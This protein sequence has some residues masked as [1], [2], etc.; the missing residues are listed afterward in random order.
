MKQVYLH[1]RLAIL[2][3]LVFSACAQDEELAQIGENVAA[4][5]VLAIRKVD[6]ANFTT[7]TATR[8]IND[9]VTVSFEAGN[10]LEDVKG[11]E[12]GI[13][14]IGDDEKGFANVSFKYIN[15]NG[16]N[17]WVNK[18][19]VSYTSKIKKA[20]AYF[21]YARMMKDG[22]EFIPSSVDELKE[23]KKKEE[24]AEFKDKDLLIA[25]ISDIQSPQLT[26]GF[27]H[28]FSLL[29]FSAEATIKIAGEE[30]SYFLDIANI[31]F[32]I[33]DRQYT[34]DLVDSKY[35]CLIDEAELPQNNFRYFYT[36]DNTA[37]VKT[38]KKTMA[39]ALN[40]CYVLP[41][42]TS[43]EGTEGFAVGDFFCVSN[44]TDNIVIIP[45]NAAAIPE[46]LTCKGVVFHVM[47]GAAFDSYK[48]INGLT[49]ELPGYEGSHGLVV[50]IK[51]GQPFGA[52]ND[53][54]KIQAALGA[55]A[56]Y[57]SLD[58]SNGYKLTQALK[59]AEG[60]NFTALDNHADDVLKNATSWYAPSFN[61][62]KYLIRGKQYN[63]VSTAGQVYINGQLGK[64][65]GVQLGGTLPSVTYRERGG[66]KG[67]Q[68]MQ[69]GVD[70]WIGMP[71]ESFIPI[72]G[73]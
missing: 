7:G 64:I 1:L 39:L 61:E 29:T 58:V 27:K 54:A 34:P 12:I 60:V 26:I 44:S 50:S 73:F 19:G 21:P 51:N 45:G 62:L 33:G 20:I 38:L 14:L 32:S 69:N 25:E 5:D 18:D 24:A 70:G 36:I 3:L 52:N 53:I 15:E 31:A 43:S 17:K 71:G 46:S 22:E 65:N 35:V 9:A 13:L 56:D 6:V 47:D 37:Y 55:V 68:T 59:G 48:E 42:P 10:S 2:S 8:V 23:F 4:S 11:D 49:D 57:N 16:A 41:C 28:A 72:C 40:Q 66:D 63:E 67:I 30:I